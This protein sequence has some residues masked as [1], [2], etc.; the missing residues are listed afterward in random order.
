MAT[1]YWDDTS[2]TQSSSNTGNWH[3]ARADTATPT[4]FNIFPSCSTANYTT[5][6]R[7]ILV[8]KP[9]HWTDE[10]EIKFIRLINK[11]TATG[12]RVTMLIKGDILIID[13]NIEKRT[14]EDF[15]PL[16]KDTATDKDIKKINKF[17]KENTLTKTKK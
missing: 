17:F 5:V 6:V 12:W 4:H 16:L 11:E 7:R 15:A 14:M 8:N 9:K 10:Q 3:S 2:V 13:P 1:T